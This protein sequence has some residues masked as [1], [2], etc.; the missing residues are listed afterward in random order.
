MGER[1]WPA[2]ESALPDDPDHRDHAAHR[3]LIGFVRL[4]RIH[5]DAVRAAKTWSAVAAALESWFTTHCGDVQWRLD[6]WVGY[7]TWQR[8]A[9]DQLEGV[10]GVL[11]EIEQFGLPLRTATLVRLVSA[12]LDSDVITTESKGAGVFVDQI[13]GATGAVFDHAFV[14]GANDHLL[15]GRVADDLVL[16]RAHGAEPLGVLTGPAN[17]PLRDERGM[18]AALDGAAESVTVTWSRWDVR[19]G[20]DLY[21]SPL[22]AAQPATHE[23]V[24][25]H[26]AQLQSND[27]AWLDAD[28]W[29]TRNPDRTTPRLSRRRRAITSRAQPLPGEFDG[30]VGELAGAN[31]L[32]KIDAHGDPVEVGITSFE[33]WVTCGL[34]YFVTRVLE[35][36]LDDTDPSEITDI[37]PREKGTVIHS[38]FERLIQEW[39]DAHPDA[40]EAWIADTDDVVAMAA[41]AEEVLDELAAPLLAAHHLGHPE[42][43]RARRAQI[44]TAIGRGLEIERHDQVVPVAAEFAFGRRSDGE[45]P[46]AD[47]GV[48]RR[49]APSSVQRFH[50]SARPAGRRHDPSDGPQVR[51]RRPIPQD[52]RARTTRARPRQAPAR[53]LR[54][55]RRAADGPTGDGVEL[56]LRRSP[57]VGGRHPSRADARGP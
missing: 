12:F 38:V 44:L 50:R 6:T 7:P 45:R 57:R 46:P 13:V 52:L 21:P 17:R 15:P 47:V 48:L 37:E 27:T 8:E 33:Q 26:A 42:M 20:G 30:Q 2:F 3:S 24:A 40:D 32:T 18:L 53:V 49:R 31:P 16:T 1:D 19:S 5:R 41:R 10:F 22:L 14:L 9:A 11:A 23:H 35:A 28:E 25:S 54:V 51:Q 39:I 36:R 29:F 55:G 34:E 4:Q 56:S 43:W